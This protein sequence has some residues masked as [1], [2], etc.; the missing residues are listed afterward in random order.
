MT[1]S[2]KLELTE[3]FSGFYCQFIQVTEED[4]LSETDLSGSSSFLM[5]SLPLKEHIYIF[6]L[7]LHMAIYRR[8]SFV[9]G[10][11]VI[12]REN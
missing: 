1:S 8:Y 9:C 11:V 7:E 3:W 6:L 5:F 4:S 10:T 12:L 2:L